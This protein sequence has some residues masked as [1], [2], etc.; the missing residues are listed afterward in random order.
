MFLTIEFGALAVLHDLVEVGGDHPDQLVRLFAP[1]FLQRRASQHLA[2]FVEQLARKGR[3]IVD[4]I[5]RVLDLVSDARGELAERGELLGLNQPILRLAQIVERG[6][7]LARARLH[8][9]EQPH[10]LDRD[11]GLVGEGLDDLNLAI[12][13]MA[14]LLAREHQRALDAAF[15]E[16]RH[17]QQGACGVTMGI[18]RHDEIRVLETVGNSFHLARREHPAGHRSP[19]RRRRML[20]EISGESRVVAFAGAAAVAKDVAVANADD[21][22]VRAAEFDGGGD[23]RVEHRLQVERRPADDLQHVGRRGLQLQQA[24][25]RSSVLRLNLFE[26]AD[27]L[28]RD[29]GLVGKR[30]DELD[31]HDR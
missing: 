13:E 8:L 5:Q 26:Q 20:G 18:H 9:V 11:D 12:G 10:V 6:G 29:D 22:A 24:S 25:E 4:E 23:Q 14:R 19:P 7:E 1:A 3:E 30:S 21:A 15:S 17:A 28:D 27:V 16:Q 31:L 2:Q